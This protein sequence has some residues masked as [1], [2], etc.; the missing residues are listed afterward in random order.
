MSLASGIVEFVELADDVDPYNV[1]KSPL[2]GVLQLAK[3]KQIFRMPL[4]DVVERGKNLD[5]GDK[6]V[7]WM[8]HSTRCGSTAWIQ[9]FASLP[10]WTAISEPQLFNNMYMN[11]FVEEGIEEGCR[12]ETFKDMVEAFYKIWFSQLD[13]KNVF[14]KNA[15]FDQ[16]LIP[17]ITERFPEHK[18]L[19]GYRNVL[20]SGFSHYNTFY[21]FVL[22]YGCQQLRNDA[23]ATSLPAVV[24]KRV[25]TCRYQECIKYFEQIEA[26]YDQFEAFVMFW[27]ST[28]TSIRN[29]QQ[30]GIPIYGVKY[31]KMKEDEK[32]Y[33]QDVFEHLGID[34]SFVDR[35]MQA[36]SVDSQ[37]GLWFSKENR[38]KHNHH[39]T[40]TK[41]GEERAT[42]MLNYFGFPDLDA[43]YTLPNTI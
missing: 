43:D 9:I 28:T 14:I 17:A 16:Y 11:E 39:W 26:P 2:L 5:V 10:D 8:L 34:V 13:S 20:P 27:C 21:H 41:E 24:V 40:R 12:T 19:Y 15:S 38:K 35:A 37:T 6:K 30:N 22:N 23:K 1:R 3:T 7:V 33:V 4:K 25:F 31:E 32:R 29:A 36:L 42:R 18:L